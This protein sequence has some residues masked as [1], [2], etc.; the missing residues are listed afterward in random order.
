LATS[1]L[2]RSERFDAG[3]FDSLPLEFVWAHTTPT[4]QIARFAA[5]LVMSVLQLD[6][7]CIRVRDFMAGE[8][9]STI[10]VLSFPAAQTIVRLRTKGRLRL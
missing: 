3:A 9:L 1:L 4:A 2:T 7:E 8:S 5:K 10:P 6:F